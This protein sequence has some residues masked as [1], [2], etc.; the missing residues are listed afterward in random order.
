MPERYLEISKSVDPARSS[1]WSISCRVSEDET[2]LDNDESKS[3]QEAKIR[4]EQ[5][6]ISQKIQNIFVLDTP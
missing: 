5:W 1:W 2:V 3:L 6:A 4:A